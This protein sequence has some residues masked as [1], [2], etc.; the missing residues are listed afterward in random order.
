MVVTRL[1]AQGQCDPGVGAWCFEQVGPQLLFDERVC[2]SDVDE[3]FIYAR[4][5][6]DQRDGIVL[7]P[8]GAIIAEIAGKC[9]LPPRH[10]A[11][12]DDRREG[13]DATEATRIAQRDGQRA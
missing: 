1:A 7:P 10:L 13:G 6:L 3:Q 11:W 12:R 4:T 8:C 2:V 5:I 9:L